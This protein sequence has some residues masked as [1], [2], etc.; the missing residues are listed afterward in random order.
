MAT[1]IIG[2]RAGALVEP[3]TI[4]DWVAD[5]VWCNARYHLSFTTAYTDYLHWCKRKGRAPALPDAYE[6]MLRAYGFDVRIYQKDGIDYKY[7][8]RI[9]LKGFRV[10]SVRQGAP[11]GQI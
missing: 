6:E 11:Y 2:S 10:D 7:I 9:Q 5:N 4:A 3:G 8:R 1:L